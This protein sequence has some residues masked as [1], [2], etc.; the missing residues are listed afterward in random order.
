MRQN[1]RL[2]D[3]DT[4]SAAILGKLKTQTALTNASLSHDT[5][6][7]PFT[8]DGIFEFKTK[9]GKLTDPT[10]KRAQTPSAAKHTA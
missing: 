2:K 1:T 3:P 4:L 5:N 10:G 7:T 9:S 6:D 8:L